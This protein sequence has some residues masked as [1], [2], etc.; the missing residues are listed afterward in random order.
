MFVR[1]SGLME[2]G[3]LETGLD[4]DFQ[5]LCHQTLTDLERI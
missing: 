2:T 1:G 5:E 4:D 3:K